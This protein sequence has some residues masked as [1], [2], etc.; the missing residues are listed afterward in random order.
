MFF[1]K[2]FK[3]FVCIDEFTVVLGLL[4]QLLCWLFVVGCWRLLLIFCWLLVFV[5]WPLAAVGLILLVVGNSF[6]VFVG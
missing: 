4:R 3:A 2:G 1:S 6:L 5:C